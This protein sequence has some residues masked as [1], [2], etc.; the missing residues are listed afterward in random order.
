MYDTAHPKDSRVAKVAK[1][2]LPV[3]ES[4]TFE[5][6]LSGMQ[7]QQY[8]D[9]NREYLA[10]GRMDCR[11]CWEQQCLI[12]KDRIA[13]APDSFPF[14]PYHMLL[15]PLDPKRVDATCFEEVA[16]DIKRGMVSA[17]HLECRDYFTAQD[18][19]TFASLVETAPDYVITQSMRGSGASIPEHIHA[20]AFLKTE[21]RF[22]LL[23]KGCYTRSKHASEL[24]T[25]DQVGYGILFREDLTVMPMSF[26]TLRHRF[27]LASNHY[28]MMNEDFGGLIG[29]Y[30]PRTASLPSVSRLAQV[31]WKFGAFEVLGLYDAKTALLFDTLSTDEACEATRSVTVNDRALRAAMEQACGASV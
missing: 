21:T 6:F 18:I 17:E 5:V 2:L 15:R 24:W 22:P 16:L 3:S 8:E 1:R 23:E 31:D 27:G 26:D 30:V 29:L 13:I 9:A 28:F 4:V 12:F 20:H 10:A 7:R 25:I 11:L 19:A 14:F